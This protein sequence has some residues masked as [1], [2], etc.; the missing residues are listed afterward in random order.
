MLSILAL[1]PRRPALMLALFLAILLPL[2]A[3]GKKGAPTP[4]ADE[5]NTYPRTYPRD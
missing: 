2:T 3:C 4:P 5:P 1:R